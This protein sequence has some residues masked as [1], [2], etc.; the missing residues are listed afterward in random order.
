MTGDS[1]EVAD[2]L[3]ETLAAESTSIWVTPVV[4]GIFASS[5]EHDFPYVPFLLVCHL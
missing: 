2:S 1:Q 4:T 3:A 5:K